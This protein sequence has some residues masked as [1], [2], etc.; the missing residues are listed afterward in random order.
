MATHSSILAWRLPRTEE[1]GRLQSI[2]SQRV[3][4]NWSD[5]A[6][7]HACIGKGN[8]NSLQYSS[9]ENPMDREAWQ[10]TVHKVTKSQTWLKWLNM[11]CLAIY[12]NLLLN[13]LLAGFQ[14]EI[15]PDPRS[16]VIQGK[17]AVAW[18]YHSYYIVVLENVY[19]YICI[20]PYEYTISAQIRTSEPWEDLV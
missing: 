2:R 15:P 19:I 4:H 6:C 11:H 13:F 14:T 20:W 16:S 3:K 10:A 1:P 7:M 9:L 5:L 8:G 12:H 18:T 17:E